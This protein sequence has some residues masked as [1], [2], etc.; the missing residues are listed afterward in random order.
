MNGPNDGPLCSLISYVVPPGLSRV[1]V[2]G[3]AETRPSIVTDVETIRAKSKREIAPVNSPGSLIDRQNSNPPTRPGFQLATPCVEPSVTPP[4]VPSAE[5]VVS[6]GSDNKSLFVKAQPHPPRKS[7]L[8]KNI[9]PKIVPARLNLKKK[10][11][12]FGKTVNVSQTIEGTSQLSKLKRQ[13]KKEDT[14]KKEM[15]DTENKENNSN[16]AEQPTDEESLLDILK[17]VRST[18]EG[19]KVRDEERAE[20][21]RSIRRMVDEKSK[22]IENLKGFLADFFSKDCSRS[23][24]LLPYNS[25]KKHLEEMKSSPRKVDEELKDRSPQSPSHRRFSPSQRGA[26]NAV[27]RN[28]DP[29]NVDDIS[30]EEFR[31]LITT[32]PALRQFVSDIIAEENDHHGSYISHRRRSD[33][34][35]LPWRD[36]QGR[37]VARE[38]RQKEDPRTRGPRGAKFTEKVTVE[39]S[40]RCSPPE[41]AQY[42]VDT[43]RYI[44]DQVLEDEDGLSHSMYRPGESVS[45]Y[46][47]NLRVRCCVDDPAFSDDDQPRTRRNYRDYATIEE[48]RRQRRDRRPDRFQD[49]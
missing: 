48:R 3:P 33:R 22:E 44:A 24:D 18:L 47:E 32:N 11:V 2:V 1:P 17:G 6:N 31:R 8:T 7:C 29:N 30:F 27:R 4:S 36:G 37:E 23:V 39:R 46:P 14:L 5:K 49:Y 38:P 16:G 34:G 12:A 15:S 28:T 41:L 19:L 42:S 26:G 45:Y 40:I 25:S 10:T 35:D 13:M 20:E 43:R 9:D 21:L